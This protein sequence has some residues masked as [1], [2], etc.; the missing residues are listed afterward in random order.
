MLTRGRFPLGPGPKVRSFNHPSWKRLLKEYRS[1]SPPKRAHQSPTQRLGTSPACPPPQEPPPRRP[2]PPRPRAPPG[3]P[4]AFRVGCGRSRGLGGVLWCLSGL[5]WRF[6]AFALPCVAV[7]RKCAAVLAQL[8]LGSACKRERKTPRM[9]EEQ[10][11]VT[12]HAL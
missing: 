3:P 6:A 2:I 1:K 10:Q 7:P 11:D 8:S 4:R 5:A 9:C 12:E